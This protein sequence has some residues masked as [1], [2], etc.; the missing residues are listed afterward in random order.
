MID[1]NPVQAKSE[2][3]KDIPL[4]FNPADSFTTTRRRFLGCIGAVSVVAAGGSAV[5]TRAAEETTGKTY[6][7]S[8]TDGNDSNSGR[9]PNEAWQGLSN[10]NSTT[11]DPGDQ[12]LFRAGDTWIGQLHPKGSGKPEEPIVIDKYGTGAKPLIDGNGLEGGVVYLYN[13]EYWEITNLEITNPGEEG[14][15]RRGVLVRAEDAGTLNHIYLAS[16][17]IHDVIGRDGWKGAWSG[18][19]TGGIVFEVV[20]DSNTKYNDILIQN[21]KLH[22]VR[23]TGIKTGS[24]RSAKVNGGENYSTNVVIRNNSIFRA[25]GDGILVAYSDSPLIE[26]NTVIRAGQYT[27][28]PAAAVWSW[29]TRNALFQL[30]EVAHTRAPKD[31]QAF[32]IDGYN[33]N[34]T[35]QYNYTHDNIGGFMLVAPRGFDIQNSTVRYNISENDS[36]Y[37]F[38]SFGHGEKEMDM[39]G[40]RVYNNSFYMDSDISTAIT[41]DYDIT[42]DTAWLEW[43]SGIL[44]N[45]NNNQFKLA[46]LSTSQD[47]ESTAY[48]VL[49]QTLTVD[50]DLSEV[51]GTEGLSLKEDFSVFRGGSTTAGTVWWRW[52][53]E[54]LYLAANL[55]D[56]EHVQR[57]DNGMTWA[58]DCIQAAVTAGEPGA[59]EKWDKLDIALAQDDPQVYHR[60]L[61]TDSSSGVMANAKVEI[62]TAK[63]KIGEDVAK[64]T[65][66]QDSPN[67]WRSMSH[68]VTVNLD[69]TP[70]LGITV[71]VAI[72]SWNVAVSDGDESAKPLSDSSRTGTFTF[73]VADE[74]GWSGEKTFTIRL[75]AVSYDNPVY[76]DRIGLYGSAATEVAAWEDEF[77]TF[78]DAWTAKSG[79]DVQIG[80]GRPHTKYEVAVPWSELTASPSNEMLGLSLAIHDVDYRKST[81]KTVFRNDKRPIFKN[82]IIYNIGSEAGNPAP[83]VWDISHNLLY[84]NNSTMSDPAKIIEKPDFSNPGKADAGRGSAATAYSLEAESPA[85][86]TGAEIPSNGGED[87]SGSGIPYRGTSVDRGALEHQGNRGQTQP[88]YVKR[89]VDNLED[90]SIIHSRSDNWQ[91]DS[92]NR[93]D[94]MDDVSRATR[95]SE[96]AGY[97]TYKLSDMTDFTAEVFYW[98]STSPDTIN[99]Y[100]STGGNSWR[101]IDVTTIFETVWVN[102]WRGVVFSSAGGLPTG[103]NYVKI[104]FSGSGRSWD[105]QLSTVIL[106]KKS[107]EKEGDD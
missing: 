21:N 67:S 73:N 78:S 74:T 8:K 81:K 102:D 58:Q 45:E 23:R 48:D 107:K 16:L 52:D 12:I 40:M 63:E 3:L 92:T 14:P 76:V 75:Y 50:G 18:K 70:Y 35:Y 19:N 103:T 61:G 13:Q 66:T 91:F 9:S 62:T 44:G 101:Q 71:P 68:E 37:I 88:Q 43:G 89:S 25:G 27:E 86:N 77:T 93:S 33:Q 6:Y 100:A 97:I 47:R 95:T 105:K 79:L 56:N 106:N 84:G 30:N 104:E 99:F 10:V 64:L 15:F 31:G 38:N 51:S 65:V 60:V 2:E 46:E 1:R 57:Y 96:T 34:T 42:A 90:W 29:S 28:Y 39:T 4:V 5:P 22:D 98:Q 20:D 69:E 80:G 94:F 41:P 87:Y 11:F 72:G 17:T 24:T 53:Q 82:N 49:K 59:A 32:D 36:L 83:G 7:V 55:I 54:Y 26:N 85:I